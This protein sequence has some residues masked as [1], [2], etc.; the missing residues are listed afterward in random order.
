MKHVKKQI[1]VPLAVAGAVSRVLGLAVK[2]RFGKHRRWPEQQVLID[3]PL[4]LAEERTHR[5]R[6]IYTNAI[7]DS[8][9]G[10][11]VFR[12]AVHKHGGIQLPREK[13]EALAH[14]MGM[15]MW[16]E[17]AAWYVSAEL[18]E[19]LDDLDARMAASSQVFDE[20]RHFYVLRDYVAL[21]HVPV[22]PL[23]PYFQAAVR[24][25][26]SAEDLT[27]KLFAMQL[28]AEGTAQ[29]IFGFLAESQVE[30]VLSELLPLIEKDEAR[31]V[32]LGIMHLPQ[33]LARLDARQC[34]RIAM[35]T[36]TIGDMFA[37]TQLRMI[38]HYRALDLD[39]R[40]LFR[41]ADRLLHG[42]GQKLGNVPGT[43]QAYFR[44][45]DPA[46]P[47]YQQN[48][49]FVLPSDG[50]I[51]RGGTAWLYR[52]VELGARAMGAGAAA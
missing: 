49:D 25:L 24:S 28:L 26:L 35:H 37:A 17:L 11:E 33:R 10:H 2:S 23:D 38:P 4:A 3:E 52:V 40:E 20:A 29:S 42:L 6:R 18:A 39:P 36:E 21:L 44:T 16:G 5:L 43:Q 19:E 34:Q 8:W 1:R 7:R 12:A 14:L 13:R 9:D 31:H 41:R 32:G 47:S 45:M 48:L 27:L 30:P 15:L 50:E 22:P 51:P 46:S